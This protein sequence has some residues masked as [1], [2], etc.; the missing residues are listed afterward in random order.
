MSVTVSQE[1]PISDAARAHIRQTVGNLIDGTVG[2]AESG[3]TMPVYHPPT[4]QQIAEAADSSPADVDRAVAAARAAFDD[5]RWRLLPPFEKERRM[6]RLSELITAHADLLA[7]LDVLDNG[8]PR[9]RARYHMNMCA[10]LAMYYAGWPS[11]LDGV[12]HPS[13]GGLMAYS[14]REP[15]GVAAAIIPWNGPTAAALWKLGPALA[16]GNSLILKPAEQTPLSAVRLA[17]LCLEAGIPDGVVN[18]VQGAGETVGAALVEHPGV[19]K[20]AFTGSTQTG[21]IVQTAAARR[22]KRVTLELG[23]KAANIVYADA[24]LD[25]AARGVVAGAWASSGQVCMAGSRLVVERSISDEL[26]ERVT[27]LT[28]PLKLGS[29]FDADTDLGPLVSVEQLSRVSGYISAGREE[30]ASVVLGGE[31]VGGDGY[32]VSPTIF[33]GVR[34]DMTI[35]QEEIFGPVLAVIGFD[36]ETEALSI[37]NDTEYGLTAGVWTSDMGKA[38]RAIT[39]IRT[40]LVWVNTYAEVLSNVPYGGMKQSGFGRE[41]GEAALDVYT[42][43]KSVVMRYG[44]PG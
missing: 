6:R 33:T 40:G 13:P 43:T 2:G 41:L 7:D 9:S 29:G 37:A 35:A 26:V 5:G 31:P 27:A 14:I 11:R 34:N 39:G 22:L 10:E 44:P 21:R 8:M 25:A 3:R 12:V 16:T 28:R 17:Q 19:D 1:L 30:G 23:G 15:V 24:D 42:E 32:F 38:Q 4:G 36:S 18:V 20:V